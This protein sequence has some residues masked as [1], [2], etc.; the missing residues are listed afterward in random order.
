M[1]SQQAKIQ[2]RNESIVRLYKAGMP[3][4]KIAK[5]ANMSI[6]YTRIILTKHCDTY[7]PKK[8]VAGIKYDTIKRTNPLN[9]AVKNVDEVWK[10]KLKQA[11]YI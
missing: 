1:T 3:V 2:A 7:K 10:E 5:A 6:S 8:R 9:K 11:G 4:E